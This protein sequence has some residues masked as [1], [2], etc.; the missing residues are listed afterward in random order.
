MTTLIPKFDFKNGG[1]T[2]AGAINRPINDKL[3]ET[4]SVKDFGATGDGTTDDTAALQAA[5][6]A[7]VP[8]YF[9][10]GTYKITTGLTFNPYLTYVGENY[11]IGQGSSPVTIKAATVGITML[12][13]KTQY[14]YQTQ[15]INIFLDGDSKAAIGFQWLCTAGGDQADLTMTNVS[16]FNCTTKGFDLQLISYS[17]FTNV[18]TRNCPIGFYMKS[19]GSSQL[20]N[21][22]FSCLTTA[23]L[24]L[25]LCYFLRIT[26]CYAFNSGA[27][28]HLVLI[29]GGHGNKFEKCQFEP[30]PSPTTQTN[31]AVTVTNSY[32]ATDN[33]TDNTFLNCEWIGISGSC[34][35]NLNIGEGLSNPN[36]IYK[37]K[38]VNCS[39]IKPAST[40]S[41][42]LAAQRYTQIFNSID[43]RIYNDADYFNV[44]VSNDSP[45]I[46]YQE[47]FPGT[48]Y[49]TVNATILGLTDGV[50]APATVSGSAFIY[51][52]ILDGDLKV[53]FGDGT[54]KTISTDT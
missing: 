39:F 37:T 40:S 38:V 36:Q 53:K 43:T 32:Y 4:T 50:D 1:A 12:S 54:V 28:T 9:P 33:C 44:S 42:E 24:Y 34:I 31:N 2:P 25:D 8:L 47:G 30:A 48:F 35:C 5:F 26:N 7:N 22:E 52:D 45:N 21:C 14:G 3:A 46:Y 15:F 23:G 41:I 6:D 17:Q 10:L 11:S 19:C 29:D 18:H 27:V 49:S 20:S 16:A 13:P 51:V